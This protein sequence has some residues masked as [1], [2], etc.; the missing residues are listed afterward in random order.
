MATSLYNEQVEKRPELK[1]LERKLEILSTTK[2]DSTNT[3]NTYN[4]SNQS[5]YN[6]AKNH[7]NLINDSLL[8]KKMESLINKS[9]SGYNTRIS[10]HNSLPC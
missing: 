9:L 8:R 2:G 3:F 7:L 5:Y 6:S 10:R 4:V 1:G